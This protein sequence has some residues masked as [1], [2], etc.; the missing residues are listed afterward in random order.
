MRARGRIGL[1]LAASGLIHAAATIAAIW[2]GGRERPGGAAALDAEEWADVELI[3]EAPPSPAAAA[4]PDARI[5]APSGSRAASE[6]DTASRSE[7]ESRSAPGSASESRPASGSALAAR[8]EPEA[9]STTAATEPESAARP[10]R[11]KGATTASGSTTEVGSSTGPETSASATEPGSG[12]GSVPGPELRID[13]R[14]AAEVAEPDPGPPPPPQPLDG[15]RPRRPPRPRSELRPDG[16]R[17]FRTDEGPFVAHTDPAG[18]V[19]FQDRSSF[20]FHVPSPRQMVKGMARGL[21]R[22][23]EDPRRYAEENGN[24]SRLEI[25]GQ[26]EMTDMA[27]RLGGQDPYAARKAAFL[28]RTREERMALARAENIQRLRESL[29]RTRSELDRLW[30]GPGTAAEKRRLLFLLWDECAESGSDEV[31]HTGR[32]VRGQ[33]VAFVRRRLPPG[34][35]AAYTAE[36]LARHN[37]RR[38]SRERFDPY[39]PA[40]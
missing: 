23:S 18:K 19:R 32:A 38:S 6:P 40:E 35:R 1:G 7:P 13:P 24:Q 8:S 17:G 33:I 15:L 4:A 34:S 26:L 29:H 12:S 30:R 37:A 25:G 21:E 10:P 20:R 2:L 9:G 5:E 3:V 27:M 11:E 31:A 36:E 22:W 28:E 16:A 14:R 39:A